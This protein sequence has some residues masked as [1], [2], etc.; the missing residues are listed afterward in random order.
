MALAMVPGTGI[1]LL[2]WVI[3]SRSLDNVMLSTLAPEW[4]ELWDRKTAQFD[5]HIFFLKVS[6]KHTVGIN[7]DVSSK[8]GL[9]ICGNVDNC[10]EPR[11]ETRINTLCR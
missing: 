4:T 10:E 9:Y 6:E 8:Y 1:L 7:P 3:A 5:R 2:Q 11:T